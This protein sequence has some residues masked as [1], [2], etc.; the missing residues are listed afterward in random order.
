MAAYFPRSQIE[1]GLAERWTEVGESARALLEVS[2]PPKEANRPNDVHSIH[3]AARKPGGLDCDCHTRIPS[4]TAE[5]FLETFVADGALRKH[6]YTIPMREA[7]RLYREER[8]S[9]A[10]ELSR[11]QRYAREAADQNKRTLEAMGAKNDRL[12]ERIERAIARAESI[13]TEAPAST[14]AQAIVG[15]LRGEDK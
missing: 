5:E 12:E 3:C 6:G 8:V 1:A 9:C 14:L 15:L 2:E 13:G 11:V 10:A 4:R 7:L